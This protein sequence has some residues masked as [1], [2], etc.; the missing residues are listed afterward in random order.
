MS[1]IELGANQIY[2]LES[3]RGIL[4]RYG[5]GVLLSLSV[6]VL[7]GASFV[8]LAFGGGIADAVDAES[9]WVWFRW[10]LGAIAVVV[11]L[12]FLFKL[13][14]NRRQPATSWLVV[15]GLI[16]TALWLVFSG[17]LANYLRLSST[18]GDVYGPLAGLVGLMIWAQLT[19]VAVLGGIAFAAELEAKRA[20]SVSAGS[21][22]TN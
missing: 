2:S 14:S 17:G 18:F 13:A 6:G 10:P 1:K 4:R 7:L 15:G 19:G 9:I 8:A 22:W 3:D 5:L 16:A 12:A 21:D 11:A 20:A